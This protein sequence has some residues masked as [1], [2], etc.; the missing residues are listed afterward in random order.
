MEQSRG[1]W[2]RTSIPARPVPAG[3]PIG[4]AATNLLNHCREHFW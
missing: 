2:N 1:D 4:G 3:A